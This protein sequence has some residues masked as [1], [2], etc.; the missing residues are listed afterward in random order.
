MPDCPPPL[1]KPALRR[2]ARREI[3]ALGD[4]C[5]ATA[6]TAIRGEILS[7]PH[8]SPDSCLLVFAA[9][10]GE[11]DL[12]P[13]LTAASDGGPTLVFPRVAAG[14]SGEPALTLH[15]VTGLDQF[16]RHPRLG[17]RE[18]DPSRCPEVPDGDVTAAFVPG[19]AFDPSTGVRLGRGGGY[20]DR[21]LARPAFRAMRV[22]TCFSAQ[23]MRGIPRAPHDQPMG[24]LLTEA[25]WIKPDAAPREGR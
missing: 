15:V 23:L 2:R 8:W 22:G 11:P 20:Y 17:I 19:L 1:D 13:L 12:L 7:S 24:C 5:V 6:S 3:G 9:L 10:A 25:G 14:P 4:E 21:L 16:A 18:P